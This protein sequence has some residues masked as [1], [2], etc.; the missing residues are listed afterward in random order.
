MD[1]LSQCRT[2]YR[3]FC[4]HHSCGCPPTAEELIEDQLWA[5]QDDLDLLLQLGCLNEWQN[6]KR[7]L[8]SERIQRLTIELAA[9]GE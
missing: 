6:G 3:L 2:C 4:Q 5:A 1:D 7:R 9:L 8:L